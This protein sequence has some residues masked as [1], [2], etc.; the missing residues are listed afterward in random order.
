VPA[1]GTKRYTARGGI[2][3]GDEHFHAKL[4]GRMMAFS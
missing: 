4:P 1:V 3:F 2:V